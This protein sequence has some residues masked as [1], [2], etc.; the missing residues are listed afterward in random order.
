MPLLVGTCE[1]EAP[2]VRSSAFTP[3]VCSPRWPS[4]HFCA[5]AITRWQHSSH[6]NQSKQT[7]A[8]DRHCFQQRLTTS[9]FTPGSERSVETRGTGLWCVCVINP[10]GSETEHKWFLLW[11]PLK[12]RRQS[13][14]EAQID[15]KKGRLSLPLSCACDCVPGLCVRPAC[16]RDPTVIQP[17]SLRTLTHQ[18]HQ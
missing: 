4:T 8:P 15:H 18:R 10:V 14:T 13:P 5:D 11:H 1:N 9:S 7:A 12:G 6:L 17:P 16:P 3:S 2:N